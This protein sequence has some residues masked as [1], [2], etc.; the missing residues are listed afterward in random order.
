MKIVWDGRGKKLIV[1]LI[2]PFLKKK[3]VKQSMD[4]FRTF[5]ELVESYGSDFSESK[6]NR[7]SS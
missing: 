7:T 1:R 2:L 3:L 6:G 5:K 4:E